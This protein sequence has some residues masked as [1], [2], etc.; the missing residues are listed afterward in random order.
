MNG[1][2][3]GEAETENDSTQAHEGERRDDETKCEDELANE[4][5]KIKENGA[6][7]DVVAV[8]EEARG[9]DEDELC[10]CQECIEEIKL[11]IG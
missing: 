11:K 2:E 6:S 7:A 1:S 8:D 4:N 9:E 10:D 5:E 3:R